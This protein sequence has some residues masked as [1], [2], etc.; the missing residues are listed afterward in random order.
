MVTTSLDAM[1]SGG[2]YDHLGG[3]FARYSVDGEW[4]VPH[5]EKM[6]YDQAL[7]ARVYLHAWQVTGEARYRQVL[8][9]TIGYVLRDLRHPTGGF[10]SAEDADS[11]DGHGHNEEGLFYTWTPGRD[12]RRCWAMLPTTPSSGGASP[13]AGNF[14]GRSILHRPVR[15]D[16]LRPE[17]I[18]QAR[19]ALFDGARAATAPGPRRQGPDRVER[20][21]AGHPGRGGRRHRR[22][23][24]GW[25]RPS[26]PASSCWPSCAGADGRW[27]PLVAGRR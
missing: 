7:L 14:E 6:L 5:F 23:R 3:G 9:E 18:E 16:L 22:R 8:D 11:P 19:Q 26:A 4:L 17:P 12:A 15:G 24:P 10:F 21:D 13:T 25:P 20:A 27:L 2:I 1:A